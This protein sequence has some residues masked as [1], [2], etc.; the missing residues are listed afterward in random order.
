MEDDDADGNPHPKVIQRN[1]L[2][3]LGICEGK[4]TTARKALENYRMLAIYTKTYG[5]WYYMIRE[6][7]PRRRGWTRGYCVLLRMIQF[8]HLLG[9]YKDAKPARYL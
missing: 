1:V 7:K 9:K 5:K 8:Y 4:G 3:K 2:V 6:S